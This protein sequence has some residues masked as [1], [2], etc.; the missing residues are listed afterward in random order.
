M[1]VKV[2]AL[3]WLVLGLLYL[4]GNAP[5]GLIE[6][7]FLLAPLVVVPLGFELL[8]GNAQGMRPLALGRV[9]RVMQPVAAFMAVASFWFPA[10]R[11]AGALASG[12]VWVG[13][14]AGWMAVV[15]LASGGW[16]SFNRMVFNVARLDLLIASCWLLVSRL[17]VTPMGFQEPI[18]LLT[19]MHFHYAGF[20]MALIAGITLHGM[21]GREGTRGRMLRWIVALVVFVPYLLA[22]GFVFS[23]MLKLVCS[24]ILAATL[25]GFAGLQF[26]SAARFRSGVA[27]GLL[28][29]AAG[30]L[31]PGMLLVIAYAIGEYRGSYW[32][33]IPQMARV[34]GPLNGP[35][36]VLLSL[37]GWITEKSYRAQRFQE[38]VREI[39][40]K[41]V[42]VSALRRLSS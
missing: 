25:L 18:V 16:R 2:G 7:L 41:S 37:V 39:D 15:D 19:G 14:V 1:W 12:W 21:G 34:H 6:L 38:V 10:G 4:A 9:V 28:R 33:A 24:L 30:L 11:V 22:A 40:R 27:R 31:I 3:C 17:G 42:R 13:A 5:F 35:G 29:T 23:A 26:F 32:L 8:D 36:F 20:A